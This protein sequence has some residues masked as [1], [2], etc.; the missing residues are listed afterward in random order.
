MRGRF[1]RVA[2]ALVALLL[3]ALA[4]LGWYV[5]AAGA[6]GSVTVLASWTGQEEAAFRAVLAEFTEETGIAVD[7]QGTTAQQEILSSQVQAGTPP[8]IAVLPSAGEL[9]QYAVGGFLHPLQDVIGAERFD[10]YDP[11]WRPSLR[12]DGAS[13]VYWFPVKVD[14]KSLVWYDTGRFGG[15]DAAGELARLAPDGDQWCVGMGSDATSGWPG[16]DWVEDI[17]LQQA[18]PEV[19]Q[20]WA[21]DRLAWTSEE[22]RR[23]WGTWRDIVTAGS[24]GT[25]A[26][27]LTTDFRDEAAGLFADPPECALRHQGSFA[28]DPGT[29]RAGFVFSSEVLP[30]ADPA[31]GARQV[32]GD[33]A[34][35][36]RDTPQARELVRF[37]ASDAA[38]ESWARNT[39]EGLPRP[40]SANARV[41]AGVYGTDPTTARLAEVLRSSDTLCL[42]ASDAMPPP[43]RDAFQR[44]VL[45]FLGDPTQM[46]ELLGQLEG[47]RGSP[48]LDAETWLPAVCG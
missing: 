30:G 15:P 33:L 24:A 44:A 6:R 2:T 40:L 31:S 20:A 34:A 37:L 42:D 1:G 38:Q 35:M 13:A 22:V 17:L 28:R 36:F 47:I 7:Y 41:P 46:E 12:L 19:Y 26:E 32:S 5:R 16:T 4:A 11:L 27:A 9:A 18:G 43:M 23:A 8:D 14:V 48:R 10:A 39:A 21:T 3:V 29:P 25:A 45:E